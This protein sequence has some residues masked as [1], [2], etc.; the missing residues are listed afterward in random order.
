MDG[1]SEYSMIKAVRGEGQQVKTIIYPNPAT[2]GKVNV[3]FE[4]VNESRNVSLTDM[5]GRTVQQWRNI[6][7][8][9]LQIEN[10]IPGIYM[11]RIVVPATGEQSI[12][13]II[14]NDR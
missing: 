4:D 9:N 12:E 1:K 7:N 2:T 14:V 8:N 13:K 5:T 10:L 11:L 3:V 6:T